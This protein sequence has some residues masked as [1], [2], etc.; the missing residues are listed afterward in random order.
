MYKTIDESF[1]A[2]LEELREFRK[3]LNVDIQCNREDGPGIPL[4]D[5]K[6]RKHWEPLDLNFDPAAWDG[7]ILA[8]LQRRHLTLKSWARALGLKPEEEKQAYRT[9][10]LRVQ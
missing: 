10:G 1:E 4:T 2:Y 6:N 9:V 8:E 5:K 7:A 3:W